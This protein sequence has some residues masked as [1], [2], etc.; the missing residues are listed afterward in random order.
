[1]LSS[2]TFVQ[3]LDFCL[4][5]LINA[6]CLSDRLDSEEDEVE[7]DPGRS[8]SDSIRDCLKEVTSK[9][10]K[11]RKAR[12][13]SYL[14]CRIEYLHCILHPILNAALSITQSAP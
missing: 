14:V 4:V 1:M 6:V 2:I 8:L 11:V 9:A 5:V 7:F 12:K 3:Y 10:G 13:L